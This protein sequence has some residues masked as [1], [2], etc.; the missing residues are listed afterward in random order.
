M[1]ARTAT[2]E[3]LSL[4]PGTIRSRAMSAPRA[5]LTSESAVPAA[6]STRRPVAA[7]SATSA[8]PPM[9]GH[10]SGS[11]ALVRWTSSG[12]WRASVRWKRGVEDTTRRRGVVVGEQDERALGVRVAR[13][14]HHVGG[15]PR[16]RDEPPPVAPA[17]GGVVGD[18]PC[19]ERAGEHGGKAGAARQRDDPRDGAGGPERQQLAGVAVAERHLLHARRQAQRG[20]PCA[21]PLGRLALVL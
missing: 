8:G 2:P 9:I 16:P 13:L 10:Q 14:G 21:Q 17:V 12:K 7:P 6:S 11:D 1:P 3:R 5:V 4:A 19:R 18:R 15:R 20:Q